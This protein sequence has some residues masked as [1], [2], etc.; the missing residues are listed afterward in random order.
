MHAGVIKREGPRYNLTIY[1]LKI[2]KVY[3]NILTVL[4]CAKRLF[5]YVDYLEYHFSKDIRIHVIVN[6]YVAV[7]FLL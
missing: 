1:L 2:M 5:G 7:Y 3:E 6:L 4:T